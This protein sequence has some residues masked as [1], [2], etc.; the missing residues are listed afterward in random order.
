[1]VVY[2]DDRK[3]KVGWFGLKRCAAVL[4]AFLLAFSAMIL[5]AN[6]ES[7]ASKIDIYCT[8]NTDGDCLV[9]MTVNLHL[10]ASDSG[11]NFP[12]PY[13]A[14]KITV[15]GSSV[16]TSRVGSQ[17]LVAIGQLTGGMTGEFTVRF[18]Y[19]LPKAVGVTTDR[20]LQLTLPMLCGFDYP[21]DSFS[22]IITLPDEIEN[23]PA[24]TSTYKQT[25]FASNLDLIVNGNMITGSSL[26][27]LNDHEAVTMTL[28]VPQEMFPSVS[29]YQR[30]G[31]PELIPMGIC[32]G[33]A[34]VYWLIFLRSRP[35][36]RQRAALPP[37]GVSA[38]ELG[39]RVTMTG[40][41][42][43]MLVLSWAQMGYLII[44]VNGSHVIL[45]K[46]MDMGNERN[47]FEVRVFQ[48]LFQNRNAVDCRSARYAKLCKKTAA[49][50]PGEKNMSE[51]K[52]KFASR[53]VYRLLLCGA[54]VF[55]GICIAM[56]M[57]SIGVL[58]VLFSFLFGACGAMIAWE[59]HE[60]ALHVLFRNKLRPRVALGLGA[61]WVVLGAIAGQPWIPLG[62]VILQLLLGYPAA[63]GG[64]RTE[65]NRNE[66][67]EIL[68]LRRYLRS[69]P[70]PEAARLIKLDPEYFF[71]MAPYA[72][73]L[74]VGKPFAAAFGRRPLEPCPY[75]VVRNN[76]DR[77]A[78]EWMRL[79]LQLVSL[80]DSRYNRMQAE[81]WMA[82][83]FK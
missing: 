5:G 13:G 48:S 4:C 46:K 62:S 80:M 8:V 1:M 2:L 19:T 68:G 21:V 9:S 25:G 43:T 57:T 12:L 31:N 73:A 7:S 78:E 66:V 35:P 65:R 51:S 16:S 70:R 36:Q 72:I 33:L 44:Q 54:Q 17:T 38:G 83:R 11:L 34:I 20:K 82:V 26:T 60:F 77:T 71:R 45:R 30:T 58:Q 28:M 67:G 32:I 74:G 27:G 53:R 56:N 40:G 61:A 47:L 18:D 52:S 15:N 10:E 76:Q 81:K 3:N 39:C 37:E 59:L 49:M 14:E 6:A 22:F 55:C 75:L 69:L 41:D 63:Y 24:F 23:T 64:M 79:M 42:L 50:I 29:T